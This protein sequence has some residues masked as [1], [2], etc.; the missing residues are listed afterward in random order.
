MVFFQVDQGRTLSFSFQ[1]GPLEFSVEKLDLWVGVKYLCAVT[2]WNPSSLEHMS[3]VTL[4]CD[5]TFPEEMQ[6]TCL[7]TPDREPTTD[8]SKDTIQVHLDEPMS[9]PG[10][11]YG[12][13]NVFKTASL[14]KATPGWVIS[15]KARD[16]EY[17]AESAGSST[18]W[19]VSFPGPLAVLNQAAWLVTWEFSLKFSFLQSE[20]NSQL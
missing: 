14:P 7:L 8:Q 9:Y 6:Y 20:E 18:G 12:S 10:V 3:T 1:G 13:R 16:L 5:R 19:R 15:H 4:L 11:T 2:N 17:T